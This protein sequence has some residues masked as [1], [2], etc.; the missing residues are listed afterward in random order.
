LGAKRCCQT[1]ASYFGF[2]V[3]IASGS[4][5]MRKKLKGASFFAL[6]GAKDISP[7]QA[8]HERRPGFSPRI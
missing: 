7:G 1:A 5:D 4:A 8:R 2:R 3:N 6:I